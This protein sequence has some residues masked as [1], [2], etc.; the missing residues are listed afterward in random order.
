MARTSADDPLESRPR[1][2]G[3]LPAAVQLAT[4]VPADPSDPNYARFMELYELDPRRAWEETG[5]YSGHEFGAY[6]DVVP[7]REIS[8]ADARLMLDGDSGRLGDILYHPELFE[9]VPELADIPVDVRFSG[10][11]GLFGA[12]DPE[13]GSVS[14]YPN[15]ILDRL[16]SRGEASRDALGVLDARGAEALYAEMLGT[17]LHEAG[18]HAVQEIFGLPSGANPYR[19]SRLADEMGREGI[20]RWDEER[21]PGV[22]PNWHVT[23]LQDR[24]DR[25]SDEI[26]DRSG[27]LDYRDPNYD[28]ELSSIQRLQDQRDRLRAEQEPY[29]QYILSPMRPEGVE[30]ESTNPLDQGLSLYDVYRLAPGETAARNIQARADKSPEELAQNYPGDTLDVDPDLLRRVSEAYDMITNYRGGF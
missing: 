23:M 7:M 6:G 20:A 14:L 18:G 12:F 30:Y 21:H 2:I 16:I 8:D 3:S 10:P 9:S 4:F 13:E 28:L 27:D 24:I 29:V 5:L 26:F 15:A 25:L 1:G 11:S 22:Q 19:A 17:L